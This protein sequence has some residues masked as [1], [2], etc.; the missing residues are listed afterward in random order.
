[1]GVANL[2]SGFLGGMG[3][4]AM[5]GL[6]TINCLNGGKGRLAPTVTALGVM[7]CTMVAYPLLN[8]IP[9]SSLAGVMIVVVLHTFKW[10]RIF[11]IISALMPH[12]WR[13][14]VNDKLQCKC[15]PQW[16]RLPLE[17]DRWE[18]MIIVVVSVLTVAYNLV[19]GVGVGLVLS[20]LRFTWAASQEVNVTRIQDPTGGKRYIL[21]GKLFFG[22]SMRFHTNFD[23]DND[24]SN[25]TLQLSADPLDYSGV[26]ALKR[27]NGLYA[28]QDKTLKIVCVSNESG[29]A[30]ETE[31]LYK[32]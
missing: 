30:E 15:Y 26:E 28:A 31:R 6:S 8:Y 12:D 27:L 11:L 20:V 10:Q 16:M 13:P 19:V 14:K 17:V 4:D 2:L 24:P 7:L 32:L 9:I 29:D 21:K 23:I 5:I 3:G 18:A 1:M 22:S 25:V